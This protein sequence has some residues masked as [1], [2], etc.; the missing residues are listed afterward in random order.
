MIAYDAISLS[1]LNKVNRELLFHRL[2]FFLFRIEIL[3]H[4]HSRVIESIYREHY[5]Y[6]KFKINI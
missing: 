2:L 5:R 3:S 4:F 1:L 6:S